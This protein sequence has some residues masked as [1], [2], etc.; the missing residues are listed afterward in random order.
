MLKEQELKTV[1]AGCY[2]Y[3]AIRDANRYSDECRVTYTAKQQASAETFK[4]IIE[5][6][7]HSK[8]FYLE[9][10]KT[11]ISI[12]VAA[13]FIVRDRKMLNE[14]DAIAEERGYEK[15]RSA[16]GLRYRIPRA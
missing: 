15:V 10:R 6:A 8:K 1:S 3:A 12:K 9:Y 5:L 4:D 13:P 14:L 16:Q 11:M 2:A 7:Y